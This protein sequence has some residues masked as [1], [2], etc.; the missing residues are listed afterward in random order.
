[1]LETP[2]YNFEREWGGEWFL[3][4]G[5]LHGKVGLAKLMAVA[6]S[7][8]K[9][10]EMHSW[11]TGN[12]NTAISFTPEGKLW[13]LGEGGPPF[14]FRLDETGVPQ[15][16][17]FDTLLDT[18]CSPMSAHPKMDWRTGEIFFHGRQQGKDSYMARIVGGKVVDRVD[19]KMRNGFEHDMFITNNYAV[20]VDGALLF[21]GKGMVEGKGKPLWAFKPKAKLRFGLFPRSCEKMTPDD[22]TW[23]EAPVSADIVHTFHAWDEGS[24]IVLWAPMVFYQKGTADEIWGDHSPFQMHRIV[25]DVDEQSVDIQRVEGA[26]E[27]ATEMPRI[28]D[29]RVGFRVRHG[30]SGLQSP[31]LYTN[32]TGI[33]KWDFDE[34]RLAG[35]IRF[36]EGVVGGEP[37]FLPRG[38]STCCD[39]ADDDGYIGMFLWDTRSEESTFALFDAQSFSPRPVAELYVPQRVP[40]GFHAAWITEDQFKRQLLTP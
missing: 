36:P 21:D 1:M 34:E 12:A 29:D 23:I 11:E 14:R 37:C 35:T 5:E 18:H 39:D 4:L 6:G 2:R 19:F 17:G 16:L 9:L 33:L 40:I 20:F 28:R 8:A 7:K 3:R 24:K 32:F 25:I 30:F 15:S 27:L 22:I 10:A 38:G 31:G 13:A 26:E